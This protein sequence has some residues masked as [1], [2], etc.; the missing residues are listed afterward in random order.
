MCDDWKTTKLYNQKLSAPADPTLSFVLNH[1][2]IKYDIFTAHSTG[3][4]WTEFVA[5][6]EFERLG[7]SKHYQVV[8]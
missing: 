8:P 1:L 7:I 5:H 3:S 4:S 2:E 6:S